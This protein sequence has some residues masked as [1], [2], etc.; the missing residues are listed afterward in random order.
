MRPSFVGGSRRVCEEDDWPRGEFPERALP[1]RPS[2]RSRSATTSNAQ[3]NTSSMRRPWLVENGLTVAAFTLFLLAFVGQVLTGAADE[4]RQRREHREAPESLAAYL[5]SGAF[6]EATAEN[7]ESEFL[8]MGV[9]VVLTALLY[10][11]GAADSK[12]PDEPSPVDE[13]PRAHVGE[14][15]V[16]WPVRRGGVALAVYRHSLSLALFTLFAL[17]FLAHAAGGARAFSDEVR[18]HGGRAVTTLGYMATS[19]F[20]FESFQNWQSEFLSVGVLVLLSIW[21]REHGSPQSKPVAAPHDD[22]GE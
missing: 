1:S 21:L 22:T 20:W 18:D 19:R 7:W 4:N 12:T 13:D 3:E 16:P 14:P 17:S 11:R 15:G 10:Q 8:Q 5:H 2:P 9:F 6:V